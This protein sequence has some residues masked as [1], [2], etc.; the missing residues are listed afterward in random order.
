MFSNPKRKPFSISKRS[1]AFSPSSAE[2]S[3]IRLRPSAFARYIAMSAFAS[4]ADT[5]LPSSGKTAM[6]T[7]AVIFTPWP[8]SCI[9]S[10]TAARIFSANS[11]RPARSGTVSTITTNSSPPNRATRSLSRMQARTRRAISRSNWSPVGWPRVS[12]MDLKL[13]RSRKKTAKP[14]LLRCA[15]ATACCKV[16]LKEAR[17]GSPVSE[18]CVAIS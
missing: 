10:L 5:S 3:L 7:L 4:N 18:S 14:L 17:L 2:Y 1:T 11:C 12:L 9:S 13:S 16:T 6:P 15:L 8:P